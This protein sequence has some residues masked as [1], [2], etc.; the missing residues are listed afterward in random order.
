[1][2]NVAKRRK[3]NAKRVERKHACPSCD[4]RFPFP[5]KLRL[6]INSNH[7][8]ANACELCP[9]RF[10]R[11]NELRTHMR[12]AHQ[13][14]HQC[15][16]CAYSSSVKAEL[17][18]HVVKCHENG[19][20]CTVDGC[21]V[22]VAYNR[23]RRH[24]KEA[25]CSSL[26]GSPIVDVQMPGKSSEP[27]NSL[28]EDSTEEKFSSTARG[29]TVANA[30]SRVE[31]VNTH[32][33][34]LEME[35]MQKVTSNHVSPKISSQNAETST[36]L[37]FPVQHDGATNGSSDSYDGTESEKIFKVEGSNSGN[38]SQYESL[39]VSTEPDGLE[40]NDQTISE[41]I[42][43]DCA[44]TGVFPIRK[45]LLYIFA[46]M[47][48][49]W[50]FTQRKFMN[51]KSEYEC[52]KCGK[53]FHNIHNSRRHWNR[54]HLK[55]Y[56]EKVKLKKYA[57]KI[58]ECTRCFSCP[59]KLQDHMSTVHSEDAP[60]DCETCNRKFRSRSS[61][62]IHLRRYHLVSIRDVPYGFTDRINV[63][64]ISTSDEIHV[65]DNGDVSEIEI[66]ATDSISTKE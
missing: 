63:S 26:Q 50:I 47:F 59:S 31:F 17:R 20:R 41:K 36:V 16:L 38:I 7:S 18:K 33:N 44:E 32:D 51:F 30:F 11:F 35:K 53:I 45:I 48:D 54:V 61:F 1:M 46:V 2:S 55:K 24:I 40:M 14:I 10:N 62:A 5:N 19:V 66:V 29:S 6:H 12:R 43:F 21:D 4:A 64:S 3:A 52:Q 49:I 27:G 15:H 65:T 37:F 22:T 58:S 28:S 60:F 42:S 23:L 9:D 25:H 34:I 56:E 39:E 13:I 57:C 8:L